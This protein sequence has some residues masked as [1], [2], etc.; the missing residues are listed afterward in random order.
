MTIDVKRSELA[1]I[2]SFRDLFLSEHNA[3]FVYN[4]CHKYGWCDDW[5][6]ILN[7]INIGYGSIW[8]SNDRKDRDAIFEFYLLHDYRKISRQIFAQFVK[9][10]GATCVECQTND[11]LLSAMLYELGENINAE[12]IL[13]AESFTSPI[14]HNDIIFRK[15]N[16][17]DN[18]GEDESDYVLVLNKTIVAS[19]GLMLNYN[20]PYADIYMHVKEPYRGKGYG[21]YIVQELKKEAYL[22]GRVPA[23][24]C[25]I[26]NAVSKQTLL[27]AGLKVCGFLLNGKLKSTEDI[28]S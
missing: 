4:K 2:Q 16:E 8:G 14:K 18:M 28:S 24:R 19:G 25:N 26:N 5:I 10:S 6:F 27:K 3:Q 21:S 17:T 20:F 11:F 13:F 15:R 23:A 22:L 7:G 12:A 9:I 1:D